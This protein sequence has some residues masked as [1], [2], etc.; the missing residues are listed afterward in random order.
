MGPRTTVLFSP[1]LVPVD[2]EAG[3]KAANEK[4]NTLQSHTIA[5]SRGGA[6]RDEGKCKEV[7]SD[8]YW[9]TFQWASNSIVC[10]AKNDPVTGR[11][12]KSYFAYRLICSGEKGTGN[13][14]G[15]RR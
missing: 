14:N 8:N 2:D 13:S 6:M 4:I 11:D 10:D 9:N 15:L 5:C 7:L 12:G 3:I 1:I